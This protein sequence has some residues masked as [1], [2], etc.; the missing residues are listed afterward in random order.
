MIHFLL[1]RLLYIYIYAYVQ[2]RLLLVSGRVILLVKTTHPE[3]FDTLMVINKKNKEK[4]I[5]EHKHLVRS[6]IQQNL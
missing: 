2:G 4:I 5:L 1:G 6:K 3:N